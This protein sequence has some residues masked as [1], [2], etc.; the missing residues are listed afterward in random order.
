MKMNCTSDVDGGE[1]A[2]TD[3]IPTEEVGNRNLVDSMYDINY[4]GDD[5]VSR[6]VC[7]LVRT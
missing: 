2:K 3:R 4:I 5:Y 7:V 6:C 1:M